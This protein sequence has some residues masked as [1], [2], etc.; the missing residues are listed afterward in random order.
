[1]E[2]RNI[3][4]RNVLSIEH[5]REVIQVT[6]GA[7]WLLGSSR[8]DDGSGVRGSGVEQEVGKRGIRVW[9][10]NSGDSSRK[11]SSK[12]VCDDLI[13]ML[14]AGHETTTIVFAWI[15]YLL[16]KQEDKLEED[17]EAPNKSLFQGS[18]EVISKIINNNLND[19]NDRVMFHLNSGETLNDVLPDMCMRNII[20][21][22][23]D[24]CSG[25]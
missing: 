5:H 16:S 21:Q 23:A 14:I 18:K 17:D 11:V 25:N 22:K 24:L 7:W 9:R 2:Q 1:M 19:H 13:T 3:Q 12:Q 10:E 6:T 15:F 20:N 4:E 8:K